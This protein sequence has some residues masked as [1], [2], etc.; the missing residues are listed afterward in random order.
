[1]YQLKKKFY[2]PVL[3]ANMNG[4]RVSLTGKPEVAI[5]PATK[6]VPAYEV[7][8]PGITQAEIKT[9]IDTKHPMGAYFEWVDSPAPAAAASVTPKKE[10]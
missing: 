5:I 9:L 3:S 1:M 10:N 2:R 4:K 7:T 8:I 6:K